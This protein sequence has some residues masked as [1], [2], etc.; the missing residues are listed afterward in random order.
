ME[1]SS[2][3]ATGSAEAG[4]CYTFLA[5]KYIFA[6]IS[7]RKWLKIQHIEPK[8]L[9]EF[10]N[11]CHRINHQRWLWEVLKYFC[12]F[13]AFIDRTAGEVTGERGDDMQQAMANTGIKPLVAAKDSAFLY[14]ERPLNQVS[15][16]KR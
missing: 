12:C 9:I 14:M 8:N 4:P 5:Y 16:E 1:G 7:N 2:D 6:N 15:W 3:A 13:Y 10:L 11:K